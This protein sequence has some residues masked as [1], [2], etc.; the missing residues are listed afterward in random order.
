MYAV[1]S[2]NW[3]NQFGTLFGIS[4]KL[5]DIHP[6]LLRNFTGSMCTKEMCAHM[7]QMTCPRMIETIFMIVQNQ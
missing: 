7:K 6:L 4:T 2:M 5:E 1:E 3:H